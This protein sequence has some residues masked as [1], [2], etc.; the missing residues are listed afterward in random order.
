MLHVNLSK[1][2]RYF[3]GVDG[4]KTLMVCYYLGKLG[5]DLLLFEDNFRKLRFLINF[6]R[7]I[8]LR[9]QL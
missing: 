3:N 6:F 7:L 1:D 9:F 2:I 8:Y 5:L 4:R